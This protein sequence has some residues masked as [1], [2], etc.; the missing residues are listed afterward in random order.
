MEEKVRGGCTS[1]VTTK[2]DGAEVEHMDRKTIDKV[3]AVE[4]QR[5]YHLI[6][7]GNS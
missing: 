2:I 1:K 4:N 7:N 3:C 6:E 5:K